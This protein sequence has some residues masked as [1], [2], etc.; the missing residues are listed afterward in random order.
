MKKS[1]A[2]KKLEKIENLDIVKE[3]FEETVIKIERELRKI[4]KVNA[5]V[6]FGSFARGDYSVRH[7]DMDIMVF[8]DEEKKDSKIEEKI[9]KK[10]IGI[11]IGKLVSIHTLFQYTRIKAEDRSLLLTIAEEGKTLF[12]KNSII[13]SKN[14][15][16]LKSLYLIIFDSKGVDQ[17]MKN[18]LQRFLHGYTIKGKKYKGIVDNEKVI[19]AGKAAIIVPKEFL[20]KILFF[21]DSI[22]IK[23]KQAGKFYQ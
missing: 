9:L 5:V 18:K 2:E 4:K 16:G 19:S 7:S 20:D 14:I 11:N 17:I 6:L 10:I 22:G 8:L 13:I 1:Y 23:A 12:S 3:Q 15:L 21:A